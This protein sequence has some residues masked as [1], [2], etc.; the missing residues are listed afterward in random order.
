VIA[1]TPLTIYALQQT[2][3]FWP[4]D[5]NYRDYHRYIQWHWLYMELGTLI[6]GTILAWKYKYPFL[7][8]P[9]AVTL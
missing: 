2:F 1:L 8:M 9:I 6:V 5:N 3:G 7:M 4:D